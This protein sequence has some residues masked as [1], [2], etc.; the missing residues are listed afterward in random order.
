MTNSVVKVAAVTSLATALV[1][2]GLMHFVLPRVTG[3]Q[4]V[5]AGTL[6]PGQNAQAQPVVYTQPDGS[7]VAL[8]AG[9]LP[10]GTMVTPV[11]TVPAAT[12]MQQPV[13]AQP[14]TVY[15]QPR[16]VYTQP[17]AVTPVSSRRRIYTNPN[18]EV[19][20]DEN[21]E[22][23][24]NERRSTGKSV[25]IVAGS[26]GAGAAIGALAGGGKGAAIGAISGGAA[27][28]IYDRMTANKKK[29]SY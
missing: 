26:A 27:G 22:P 29:S 9:S 8:P 12:A 6:V 23:I 3:D 24:V 15:A 21:G 13:Y 1:V 10:P 11:Q 16:T 5:Q 28:F 25:A 14:R 18:T 20:R 2:G 17:A 7:V 4:P 19:V